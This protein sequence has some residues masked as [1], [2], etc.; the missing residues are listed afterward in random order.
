MAYHHTPVL[1]V[2]ELYN[3]VDA[4]KATESEPAIH[5]LN[6]TM[7]RHKTFVAADRC[8]CSRHEFLSFLCFEIS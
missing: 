1:T 6:E 5:S 3:L 4:S 7:S 2:D 8:S